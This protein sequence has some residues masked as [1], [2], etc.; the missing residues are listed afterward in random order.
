MRRCRKE[1]GLALALRL[2]RKGGEQGVP[3]LGLLKCTWE[4]DEDERLVI[5]S[6]LLPLPAQWDN[7]NQCSML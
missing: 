7:E 3:D 4:E 2:F 5:T 1:K 6:G